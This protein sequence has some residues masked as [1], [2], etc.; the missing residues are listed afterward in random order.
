MNSRQTVGGAHSVV[1]PQR[2]TVS[3]TAL[4]LKRA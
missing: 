1:T 2:A 3:S 4:A